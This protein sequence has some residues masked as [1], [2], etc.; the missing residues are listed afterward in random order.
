[1]RLGAILTTGA[2]EVYS[3]SLKRA[4]PPR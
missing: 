2:G 1:L 3:R 4:K